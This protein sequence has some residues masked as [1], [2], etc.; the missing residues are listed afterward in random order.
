MLKSLFSNFADLQSEILLNERLHNGYFSMKRFYLKK[1]FLTG[2]LPATASDIQ[3]FN[4]NPNS[5]HN[6]N[7]WNPI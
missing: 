4:S 7:C 1:W 6:Q 2:H 5:N 3:I